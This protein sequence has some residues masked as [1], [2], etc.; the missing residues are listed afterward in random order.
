MCSSYEC[1]RDGVHAPTQ[2]GIHGGK[3]GAYSVVLSGGY[4][5]DDRD[6]GDTLSVS[7]HTVLPPSCSSPPLQHIHR[8]RR[9]RQYLGQRKAFFRP[10]PSSSSTRLQ[11]TRVHAAQSRRVANERSVVRA[12]SQQSLESRYSL[13]IFGT[14]RVEQTH[15]RHLRRRVTPY[16]LYGATSW[17]RRTPRHG[18][19]ATTASIASQMYASHSPPLPHTN[20]TLQARLESGTAGKLVCKFS[21]EVSFSFHMMRDVRLPCGH[22]ADPRRR[23]L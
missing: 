3:E 18:V 5:E 7:R 2:A 19:T 10:C 15:G 6:Y 22:A 1:S 21:F 11:L 13:P 12:P 20:K 23:R 14:K 4:Y 9:P 16:A 17:H 8:H